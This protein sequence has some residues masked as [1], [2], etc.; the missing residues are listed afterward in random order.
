MVIPQPVDALVMQVLVESIADDV[1][2]SQ[3][4]KKA[5]YSRSKHTILKPHEIS[6]YG[7]TLRALWIKL[8]KII[9]KFS[10]DKEFIITTDL[11]NYYDSIDI[12]E[13][14]KVLTSYL[15][16]HSEVVIDLL[17]G[18]IENI[19]WHPD[20][21][22][23]SGRGLPTSNLEAIRLLAHSFLFEVDAVLKENTEDCFTRWMDDIVIGL[24]QKRKLVKL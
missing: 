6:E 15:N 16:S 11:S 1:L 7:L 18:I 23:Y 24:I 14:K 19:S 20:Y 10:K 5:F 4:S 17:F 13:L 21:L 9:Y 12:R 8:Q 2:E 22:P 3:P